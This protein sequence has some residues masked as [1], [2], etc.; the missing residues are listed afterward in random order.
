MQ[1][2][3][4]ERVTGESRWPWFFAVVVAI[5]GVIL[6][7]S[8]WSVRRAT[9]S[10]TTQ[11]EFRLTAENLDS[12]LLQEVQNFMD[13]LS[14]I[15]QLHNL[16]DQ[17]SE[18]DFDE[19]VTKGMVYPKQ[20]LRGFGFAQRRD[21]FMRAILETG[22]GTNGK[23]KF[24]I[25]ERAD[26][27]QF[28]PAGRK[29]IYYPLTYQF[30]ANV[31]GVPNGFDFSSDATSS[32][33]I[34]RMAATGQMAFGG[35]VGTARREDSDSYYLF[36][37]I[38]YSVV[39][40]VPVPSP[41]ALIGFSVGVFEPA[42]ILARV[43]QTSADRGVRVELVPPE[44]S[45]ETAAVKPSALV[46][47]RLFPIADQ[48]WTIRC[49]A[50]PDYFAAH[51]GHRPTMV[52]LIGLG[53]TVLLTTEL[54]FMAG[55]GRRIERMI[56]ARTAALQEAKSMLE[57][58]MTQRAR[59]E[60]EILDISSREKLRVGQDLHD[61]L[62]QKLTGA[63]F[64]SRALADKLAENSPEEKKEAGRINELLK[65]A[66]GQVR[67]IAR[68]LA[69]VELGDEGIA[70]ALQRLAVDTQ[71]AFGTR[72]ILRV[73]DDPSLPRGATALQ[74]YHIAQEAVSNATRH[75][76]AGEI[77]IAL[78]AGELAIEDNGYRI[79]AGRRDPERNGPGDHALPRRHDRRLAGGSAA[80][81]GRDGGDVPVYSESKVHY[82]TLKTFDAGLGILD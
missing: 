37:P 34:S 20:I 56:R 45:P 15:G 18:K 57:R 50:E 46:Y 28:R 62:G 73:H 53:L 14:S 33:A 22:D 27:V 23:R 38:L 24:S 9:E 80:R 74:L 29:S 5:V 54:L 4:T 6:S 75:G 32:N 48:R 61:S 30:P 36:A 65:E 69:P 7:L 47:E 64:L 76:E 35:R 12:M 78:S 31:L 81:G 63:I 82:P 52:L 17:I 40:G 21:D 13:V 43:K 8:L 51:G 42:G 1:T 39:N 79:A 72:C 49:T 68:G 70:G 19:F 26:G 16:S 77:L 41:G 3:T 11:E 67:R 60:S 71:E 55:R 58:E 2:K 10:R 44:S 25:V 66:L 59:L